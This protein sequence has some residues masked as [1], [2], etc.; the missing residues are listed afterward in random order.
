MSCSE[1]KVKNADVLVKIQKKL[2][3]SLL[4]E[5]TNRNIFL[6]VY[7]PLPTSTSISR[8]LVIAYNFAIFRL[9]LI[10]LI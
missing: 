2:N 10:K 1:L 8:L 4:L 9:P 3:F 6:K 5:V 7:F